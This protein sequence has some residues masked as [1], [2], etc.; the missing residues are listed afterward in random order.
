LDPGLCACKG[1]RKPQECNRN[2]PCDV[3]GDAVRNTLHLVVTRVLEAPRGAQT[4]D[5]WS[6]LRP[7]AQTSTKCATEL[8]A[9]A[10]VRPVR[11]GVGVL[12]EYGLQEWA[13]SNEN[14]AHGCE[15]S[16]YA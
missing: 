9:P 8:R 2:V 6:A 13:P 15:N 10:E 16:L 12:P 5:A 14:F 3:L 1:Q 4:A 11:P 7:S